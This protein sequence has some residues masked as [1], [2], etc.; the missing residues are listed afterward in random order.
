MSLIRQTVLLVA[1]PALTDG[2]AYTNSD[3]AKL[4]R[5]ADQSADYSHHSANI[6]AE[7]R[8]RPEL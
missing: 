3:T 5:E 6:E 1:A 2:L 8:A 4:F 7:L